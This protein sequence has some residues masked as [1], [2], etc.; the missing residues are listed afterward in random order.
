MWEGEFVIKECIEVSGFTVILV[1]SR[2][3]NAGAR[4]YRRECGE[5]GADREHSWECGKA[6]EKSDGVRGS[7]V[8]GL[9][10][11]AES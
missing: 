5:H 1:Y 3:G 9:A 4:V 10:N 6:R 11:S 7:A 2:R 8:E